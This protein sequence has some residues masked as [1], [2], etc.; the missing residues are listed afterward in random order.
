MDMTT[1]APTPTFGQRLKA[2][3]KLRAL[4]QLEL[5]ERCGVS[6]RHLAFLELDKSRPSRR[7]VIDLSDSLRLPIDTQNTLLL[8]AGFAAAYPDTPWPDT[9]LEFVDQ[10]VSLMLEKQEP[11]PA[12]VVDRLWNIQR[13]NAGCLRLFSFLTGQPTTPGYGAAIVGQN[14]LKLSC[15][16]ALLPA[17]PTAREVTREL[18]AV[19][20]RMLDSSLEHLA[21]LD[22]LEQELGLTPKHDNPPA[23]WPVLPLVMEKDGVRLSLLSTI[24]TLGTPRDVNLQNTLIE[25]FFPADAFTR[26]WFEGGH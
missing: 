9:R 17:M 6:Q 15:S 18:L 24:T 21:A 3:R 13:V 19:T 1:H 23:H 4:S 11:Y 14:L 26:A 22:A 10:A 25:S 16:E 8:A 2:L 5:S 7:M 12:F 20:R